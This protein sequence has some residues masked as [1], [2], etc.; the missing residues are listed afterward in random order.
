MNQ[1]TVNPVFQ[2]K[3]SSILENNAAGCSFPKNSVRHRG[4]FTTAWGFRPLAVVGFAMILSKS[5]Y[6]AGVFARLNKQL[7]VRN[8]E[9]EVDNRS[10]IVDVPFVT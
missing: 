10:A 5:R 1:D 3:S 7:E 4:C 9:G 8:N 6:A 2:K